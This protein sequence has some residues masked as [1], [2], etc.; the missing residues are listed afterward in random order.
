[1]NQ[2]LM[3]GD[4]LMLPRETMENRAPADP[5][6]LD[7]IDAERLVAEHRERIVKLEADGLPSED[8]DGLWDALG[9]I[10]AEMKRHQALISPDAMSRG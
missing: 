7:G 2:A 9:D 5:L 3:G 1:V 8:V 10:L 4:F 6:R